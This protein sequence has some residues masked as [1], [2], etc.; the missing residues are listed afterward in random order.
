[1]LR[2]AGKH[3]QSVLGKLL[4]RYHRVMTRTMLRC[5]IERLSPREQIVYLTDMS[6]T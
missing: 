5:A 1:M 6:T 3:N 2:E 4:R